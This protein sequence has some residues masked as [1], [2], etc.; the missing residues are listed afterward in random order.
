MI[1]L[2]FSAPNFSVNSIA[3]S[4]AVNLLPCPLNCAAPFA[5]AVLAAAFFAGFGAL[6][7]LPAF[8]LAAIFTEFTSALETSTPVSALTATMICEGLVTLWQSG[9]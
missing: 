8:F 1:S 3:I 4:T 6:L 5:N 9:L 7:I 2:A